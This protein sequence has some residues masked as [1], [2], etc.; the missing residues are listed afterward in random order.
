MKLQNCVTQDVT[1]P[2]HLC[3]IGLTDLYT[4][5]DYE[6]VDIHGNVSSL[7]SGYEEWYSDEP[8]EKIQENCIALRDDA[9]EDDWGYADQPCA[10]RRSFIC[11]YENSTIGNLE[12]QNPIA[13]EDV[14]SYVL[15][16]NNNYIFVDTGVHV[17]WY[18]ANRYCMI[19]FRTSLAYISWAWMNLMR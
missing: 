1:Y 11:D 10:Q 7:S 13:N 2:T 15:S 17:S 12:T 4:E 6:W 19:R 14:Y 9:A 8:D 16:P 5:G 3:W 18:Y